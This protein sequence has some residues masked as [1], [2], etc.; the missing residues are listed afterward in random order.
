MTKVCEVLIFEIFET[1]Y[2]VGFL[3][4]EIYDGMWNSFV[5]ND[6]LIL[7]IILYLHPTFHMW[8]IG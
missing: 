4:W 5:L 2:R 1:R 3:E 7:Y 6:H 8:Q